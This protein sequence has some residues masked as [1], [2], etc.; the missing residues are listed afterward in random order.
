MKMILPSTMCSI[1]RYIYKIYWS[2]RKVKQFVKVILVKWYDLV[3][4]N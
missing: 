2:Q 4:T 3:H 1:N